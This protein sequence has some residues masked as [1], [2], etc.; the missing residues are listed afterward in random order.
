MIVNIDD[1][2]LEQNEFDAGGGEMWKYK[3]SYFT[4]MVV[5]YK[6]GVLT[7]E[8]EVQNGRTEGVQ[9]T[10]YDNGQI[11][12]EYFLHNNG[13]HGLFRQWDIHGNLVSSN[14]WVNGVKA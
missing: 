8:I 12:T 7:D 2:E 14:N 3:G 1:P 13:L 11:E 10:Y 9:R 4:G 5:I 6:N